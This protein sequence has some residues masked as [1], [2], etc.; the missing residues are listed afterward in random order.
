MF[1]L[2][3][4]VN[5]SIESDL[6]NFTE[7]LKNSI[8]SYYFTSANKKILKQLSDMGYKTIQ[9]DEIGAPIIPDIII[10]SEY[11][12]LLK[13]TEAYLLERLVKSFIELKISKVKIVTF[14]RNYLGNTMENILK[15]GG[16]FLPEELDLLFAFNPDFSC[17]R[18]INKDLSEDHKKEKNIYYCNINNKYSCIEII[19]N[20]LNQKIYPSSKLLSIEKEL[21]ITEELIEENKKYNNINILVEKEDSDKYNEESGNNDLY[22]LL[23]YYNRDFFE[24][25]DKEIFTEFLIDSPYYIAF[26]VGTQSCMGKNLTYGETPWINMIKLFKT[27]NIDKDD[28]F[29]ELGCGTGRICMLVNYFFGLKTVGIDYIKK[30]I[31]IANKIVRKVKIKNI[32]FF[33]GDF[34]DYDLSLGTIFYVT[35]TCFDEETLKRLKKKLSSIPNRA[36]VISVSRDLTCNHLLLINKLKLPYYWSKDNVYIYEKT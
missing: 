18:L 4:I 33:S 31:N 12:Y 34:F 14:D 7:N 3:W 9:I 6:I 10:F 36:K 28:I 17:I 29:Y 35:P 11:Y 15:K 16:V 32:K 30:F 20:I 21:P 1:I 25:I 22:D 2:F 23:K 8:F 13:N 24:K 26:K 27:I 19:E 5:N